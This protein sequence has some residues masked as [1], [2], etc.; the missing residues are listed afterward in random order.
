MATISPPTISPPTISPPT[1]S[2]PKPYTPP[3]QQ[4]AAPPPGS[5]GS[6][7]GNSNAIAAN[8]AQAQNNLANIGKGGS[9]KRFKGGST[10]TVPPV[11]IPYKDPGNM[12]NANV[13]K[14]IM[15]GA[16]LNANSQ[17]DAC[18]GSTNPA[19]GQA[20]GRKIKGGWPNWGCMSGGK[21][22]SS[23][24]S[25]SRRKCRKTRKCRRRKR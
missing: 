18:V 4:V 21:R 1:I 6:I 24:K 12:T 15:L 2:P 16:T 9:R 20:G 22:K 5:D 10:I 25:K 19:C 23:K 8:N 14:S 3:Q 13:N 17:F 11:Q 7:Y